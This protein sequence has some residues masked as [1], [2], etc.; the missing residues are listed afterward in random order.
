MG[1]KLKGPAGEDPV[2]SISS[3]N[4]AGSAN[5]TA[6]SQQRNG[7]NSLNASPASA[8]KRKQH[9]PLQ[10]PN[11][12]L[13]LDEQTPSSLK[14]SVTFAE[15]TKESDKIKEAKKAKAAAKKKKAPK[16]APETKADFSLEPALAYL[17]QWRTDRESW[18]FNK[19]H[20]TLL[21]K[22]LFDAE[23]VPSSE[24]PIFYEYIRDLKGAVRTRLRETA[25]EIKKEDMEKG[26]A[27]FPSSTKDKETKQKEYQAAVQEFI[28]VQQQERQKRLQSTQSANAK[29]SFD[30]AEL[31][32]R[33]ATPEVKQRLLKRIRSEM[34]LDELSDSEST[35]ST[36]TTMTTTSTTSSTAQK[37]ATAGDEPSA[38]AKSNDGSLQ[39]AKRRRLRKVRTEIED[40]ESSDDS[41]SDDEADSSDDDD[42]E[43]E[44]KGGDDSS[45]SSSSDDDSDEEMDTPAGLDD[46]ESSSSSSSSSGGS[47]SES[48]DSDDD[49][50]SAGDSS[51]DSDED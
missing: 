17:R 20:Q 50:D 6:A 19:N 41:S 11:K 14:K 42:D 51:D 33:V 2:S 36:D 5:S 49:E 28:Q 44:K 46:N 31:V 37:E 25:Q 26:S 8:L 23:K 1:L 7:P 18:K 4:V 40:D 15:D 30:E 45:S 3:G 39:P 24:I 29:R 48:G 12:K 32:I 21:I 16:K 47:D 35:A 13:R 34:V 38:A 27:A 10:T 9:T 43:K 22:Y